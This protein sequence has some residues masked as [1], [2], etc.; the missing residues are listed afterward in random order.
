MLQETEL[1]TE[2]ELFRKAR[3]D[4]L[5]ALAEILVRAEIVADPS[6][7]Y[8]AASMATAPLRTTD[9]NA[10]DPGKIFWGYAIEDLR[11]N[12]DNNW[13]GVPKN[14][15]F[16][17][18][19][20]TVT[21]HEYV[22]DR[23]E[24]VDRGYENLRIADVDF[25]MKGIC[26]HSDSEVSEIHCAWHLDTHLYKEPAA[27][28]HP[29]HHFQFGGNKVDAIQDNIRG[30]WLPDTPRVM[31]LPLDGVLAIDFVLSHYAGKAWSKLNE[32]A[33]YL[34]LRRQATTR[35]WNP[36]AR[37]I[38]E[39]FDAPKQQAATH[40]ALKILPNLAWT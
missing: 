4:E 17:N 29:K 24:H 33:Q 38:V 30:L 7:I 3:A 36:I 39:F 40:P 19:I 26:E 35:Y 37:T 15:E 5:R 2:V 10:P 27:T 13:K 8:S 28:A 32:E 20:L 18:S 22:P 34:E 14:T 25:S 31:T 6:P 23:I 9:I 12:L 21:V 1:S 11:L 16:D